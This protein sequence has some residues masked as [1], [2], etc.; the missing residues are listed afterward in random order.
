MQFSKYIFIGLFL[1]LSCSA[2][3][4]S[5][6]QDS[7]ETI[8]S[9]FGNYKRKVVLEGRPLGVFLKGNFL[10][11]KFGHGYG[12]KSETYLVRLNLLEGEES[13]QKVSLPKELQY[14]SFSALND[15]LT[16]LISPSIGDLYSLNWTT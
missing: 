1:F 9:V 10:Y 5:G 12:K 15:S 13:A 3:T 4:R 6:K 8:E 16:Y 11:Y 14:A 7:L 2:D